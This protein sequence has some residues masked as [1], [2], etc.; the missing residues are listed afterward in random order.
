MNRQ[1]SEE[2]IYAIESKKLFIA[3]IFRDRGIVTIKLSSSIKIQLLESQRESLFT[4]PE[5]SYIQELLSF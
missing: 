1:R 2:N 3:Q 5:F 4:T